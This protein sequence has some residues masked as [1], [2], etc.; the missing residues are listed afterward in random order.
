MLYVIKMSFWNEKEIKKIF[1][2]LPFYN[3]LMEKPKIKHLSKIELLYELP[4]F[5]EINVEIPKAFK[6]YARQGFP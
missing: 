5:D 6:G 3:V 4:F 1:Q 2:E